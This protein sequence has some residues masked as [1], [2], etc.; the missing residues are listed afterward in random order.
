MKL[1]PNMI[2]FR[3]LIFEDLPLMYDWI[4]N[5]RFVNRFWAYNK[6]EPYE[7]VT[8]GIIPSW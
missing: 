5:D 1:D 8:H 4:R 7:K 6:K 3:R 2:K